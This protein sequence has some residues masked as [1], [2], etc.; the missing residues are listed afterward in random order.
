MKCQSCN[1]NEANTHITKIIN[2]AKTELYLCSQCANESGE[3]SA[4]E[5]GFDKEFENFFNGFFGSGQSGAAIP[6]KTTEK[7]CPT[8]G[9]SL[10]EILKQGRLGCSRCYEIYREQLARPLKQI[11]GAAAHTGKIPTRCGRGIKR[12]AQI[13]RMQS[14]LNRAVMEQ[15]FEK[16]AELR[17]KINELKNQGE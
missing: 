10:D 6:Q 11:H 8:C 16:A 2:G 9:T 1:K 7:Q 3:V 5:N 14:E 17:D 12:M 13:D 15:N 4:F